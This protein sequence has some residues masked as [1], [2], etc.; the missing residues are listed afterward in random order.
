MT[1]SSDFQF[2]NGLVTK[3]FN[4]KSCL[5][6]PGVLKGGG[7]PPLGGVRGGARYAIKGISIGTANTKQP[8]ILYTTSLAPLHQH[9]G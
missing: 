6:I 7:F 1:S 5:V 3:Q 8:S 9:N 4:T 2:T